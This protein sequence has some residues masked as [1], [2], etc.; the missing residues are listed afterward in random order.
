MTTSVITSKKIPPGLDGHLGERY[1]C[2]KMGAQEAPEP[3]PLY[4]TPIVGSSRAELGFPKNL[5]QIQKLGEMAAEYFSK[6]GTPTIYIPSE[7]VIYT[8]VK[9][10]DSFIPQKLK[11]SNGEI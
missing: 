5:Q 6:V 8:V 2:V 3:L 1:I 10:G 11:V 4:I 7:S 9:S